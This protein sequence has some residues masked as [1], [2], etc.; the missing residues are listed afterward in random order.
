MTP[1]NQTQ[2]TELQILDFEHLGSF[3]VGDEIVVADPCYVESRFRG[4]RNGL[5]PVC[6]GLPVEPGEW[7]AFAV[8]SDDDDETVDFLLAC[9]NSELECDRPFGDVECLGVVSVDTGRIAIVDAAQRDAEVLQL[10]STLNVAGSGPCVVEGVGAMAQLPERGVFP[11]YA[12]RGAVKRM[13][14]VAFGR[15]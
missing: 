8:R 12:S 6:H 1:A 10:A 3:A 15:D 5:L 4:L 7:Q 13:L 11:V 2:T 9:H 14:F